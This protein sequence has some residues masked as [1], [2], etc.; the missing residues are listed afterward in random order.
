MQEGNR[1]QW[2]FKVNSAQLQQ[3]PCIPKAIY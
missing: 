1:P 2:E 3:K